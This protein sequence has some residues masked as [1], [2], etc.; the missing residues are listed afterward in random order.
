M[1][2]AEKIRYFRNLRGISQETL[3]NLSGIHYATI[4]KYELG[5]RNPK[6]EQLQKI[7]NA[8]GISIN[9]FMDQEI[10]TV[11]DVLS[12][13]FKMDDQIDM[14]FSAEKDG[15]GDYE[16]STLRITFGSLEVNERL[17]QYIKAKDLLK[18]ARS[19]VDENNLTTAQKEE[20]HELD[21]TIEKIKQTLIDSNIIIRKDTPGITVKVPNASDYM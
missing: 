14:D 15:N 13:L 12:I 21:Q 6:P 5:N 11:S 8:L 7:A 16:P 17:C 9:V 20:L 10:S 4:K 1:T 3:G 18:A 19:S 2:T